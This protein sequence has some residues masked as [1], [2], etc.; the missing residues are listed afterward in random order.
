MQE[1]RAELAGFAPE[2]M[3]P[4]QVEATK[5]KAEVLLRMAQGETMQDFTD[6]ELRT[7][8]LNR[9]GTPGHYETVQLDKKDPQAGRTSVW[10]K[11][12]RPDGFQPV[13]VEDG[14]LIITQRQV[15]NLKKR[16]PTVAA[17]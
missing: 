3:A 2:G 17:R 8:G 15:D 11:G 16:L 12:V 4:H 7:V 9:D 14:Q 13:V 6:E 1:A 5:A 10:K